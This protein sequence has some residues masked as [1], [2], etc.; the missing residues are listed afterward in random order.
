MK[1]K[2]KFNPKIPPNQAKQVINLQTNNTA[3][4][5]RPK[6]KQK[7]EKKENLPEKKFVTR[8][9]P[10]DSKISNYGFIAMQKKWFTAL[11]WEKRDATQDRENLEDSI[12]VWNA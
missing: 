9:F 12:I 2:P 10:V 1:E 3:V 7:R 11:G 6:Q 5:Q 4:T 8:E